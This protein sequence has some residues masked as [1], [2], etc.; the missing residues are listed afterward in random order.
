M[1]KTP[2]PGSEEARNYVLNNCVSDG[3]GDNLASSTEHQGGGDTEGHRKDGDET[4]GG[5]EAFDNS[6]SAKAVVDYRKSVTKTTHQITTPSV[7]EPSSKVY[8]DSSPSH[9]GGSNLKTP[10]SKM[11]SPPHNLSSRSRSR[12]RSP[13][14]SLRLSIHDLV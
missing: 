6:N 10:S 1:K 14:G 8:H 11:P 7:M 5:I 2:R 12:S 9:G 3:A 4:Y 13:P